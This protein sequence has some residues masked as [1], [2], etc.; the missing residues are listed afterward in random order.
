LKKIKI[1]LLVS[2]TT[3]K[4]GFFLLF[5]L[6]INIQRIRIIYKN[7]YHMPKP[8]TNAIIFSILMILT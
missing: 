3:H 5:Y 2:K 6:K 7:N 8:E 1:I 4:K